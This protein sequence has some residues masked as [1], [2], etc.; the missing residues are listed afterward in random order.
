[1]KPN[2]GGVLTG[3]AIVDREKE[4]DSIWNALQNQSVVISSE[5][6]VGKTCILRKMLENPRDGWIPI[7]YLVEGKQH[8]VEFIEGLY[9]E[10]QTNNVLKV[11][12]PR[13]KKFYTK[14]AKGKKLGSWEL[15]RLMENWKSLLDSMIEDTVNSGQKV[16]VMLDELPLMIAGFI[17]LEEIGPLGS[18]DFLDTLRALRNKYEASKNIVFIFCGSIGMHLVIND[19]KK[20][21]AYNSD[22][23]NN[24]RPISI[25]GMDVEGAKEL[26]EKL[27]EDKDFKFDG[28]DEIFDYICLKTD[29][30]PFY[31]HHVF[32]Y[33]AEKRETDITKKTIDE[34]IDF[35]LFDPEDVGFFRQYQDRIKTYYD[36]RCREIALEILDKAS[37]KE[38]FWKEGDIIDAVKS[39][40]V[41]HN[42]TI[43][44]AL[45]L[46]WRDH[47]LIREI[48]G[49]QRTYKFR[50]TILQKWWR[51]NRGDQ[52]E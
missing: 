51:I 28:R 7:L 26:C 31:I 2:P 32:A 12:F 15:P 45:A 13:L 23:L 14:Y 21:H 29:R 24:M 9:G 39:Q 35:L 36:E 44:E 3:D 4:I 38:D 18:M 22:P 41:L 34:A 37:P 6:R 47:Y 5:R 33:I 10:L 40:N 46:L 50:Y 17:K 43:K 1:M 16:L 20:N 30:L 19:L 52:N 11:R 48:Q 25:S 42:E 8:P 49:N 27:S